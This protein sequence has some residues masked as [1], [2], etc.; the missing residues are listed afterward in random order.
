MASWQVDLNLTTKLFPNHFR[1]IG[2]EAKLVYLQIECH[3]RRRPSSCAGCMGPRDRPCRNMLS[4]GWSLGSESWKCIMNHNHDRC[5]W[6]LKPD[7]RINEYPPM[8]I[9]QPRNDSSIWAPSQNPL[10]IGY[11]KTGSSQNPLG[12]GYPK[13]GVFLNYLKLS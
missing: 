3:R 1:G 9:S 11:P 6:P 2:I 5:S 7:P 10:G 12:I 8:P 4:W 13:T